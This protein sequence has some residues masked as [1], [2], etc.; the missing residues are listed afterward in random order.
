MHGSSSSG[1]VFNEKIPLIL[2][3]CVCYVATTFAANHYYQVTISNTGTNTTFTSGDVLVNV[4]YAGIAAPPTSISVPPISPWTSSQVIQFEEDSVC[5]PN[6][7]PLIAIKGCSASLVFDTAVRGGIDGSGCYSFTIYYHG[8]IDWDTCSSATNPPCTT[9]LVFNVKNANQAFVYFYAID[10]VNGVYSPPIGAAA[11]QSVTLNLNNVPCSDAASGQCK[12]AQMK[13]EVPSWDD[14]PVD[15]ATVTGSAGTTAPNSSAPTSSSAGAGGTGLS[16]SASHYDPTAPENSGSNAPIVFP[17]ST[18]ASAAIY[19]AGSSAI[20]SAVNQFAAQNHV[21]LTKIQG[22]LSGGLAGS[23]NSILLVGSTNVFV[24]NNPDYTNLLSNIAS[25]TDYSE[26][27]NSYSAVSNSIFAGV[28]AGTNAGFSAAG[29]FG[30]NLGNMLGIA[31]VVPTIP[32]AADGFIEVPTFGLQPTVKIDT[33]KVSLL[34][35]LRPIVRAVIAAFIWLRTL[36]ALLDTAYVCMQRVLNQRQVE[37]NKQ[38][39]D[40]AGF[41]GNIDIVTAGVYAAA[42]AALMF[43]MPVAFAGYVT[44]VRGHTDGM[45]SAL[46]SITSTPMW[47]IM[48]TFIPFD[49]L[50]TAFLLGLYLDSSSRKFW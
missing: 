39:V 33:T 48:T 38:L 47:S 16:A 23:T 37:G 50:V 12:V 6:D 40:A 4:V 42:I 1:Q 19:E 30:V 10:L 9:N 5:T 27:S 45:G 8:T 7:T 31:P 43:S 32:G 13:G 28:V 35:T 44:T 46:G 22:E 41:G 21:D 11:G 24:L 14:L 36:T 29:T 49:E 3:L 34:S 15:G 25:N 17:A 26:F 18:N 20:D 2:I